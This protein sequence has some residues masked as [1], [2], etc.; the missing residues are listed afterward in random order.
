MY[1]TQALPVPFSLSST[2]WLVLGRLLFLS[3]HHFR[4]Y[5]SA[6]QQNFRHS[7]RYLEVC[8]KCWPG[9]DHV[10]AW[11]RGRRNWFRYISGVRNREYT[12]VSEDVEALKR[13]SRRYPGTEEKRITLNTFTDILDLWR[14]VF[15][16]CMG[17][18]L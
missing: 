2:G 14:H 15:T 11:C 13:V 7:E 10:A 8:W 16:P 1:V 3:T 5:L 6:D 4:R 17:C 9:I 12:I 18:L